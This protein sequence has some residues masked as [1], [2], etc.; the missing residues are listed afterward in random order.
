MTH[1][2]Y[3]GEALQS[4]QKIQW[5][6]KLWD[7]NDEE[8]QI[9]TASF[10]MGLLKESDWKATWITGDYKVDR[11][12][13]YP[14]DCFRKKFLAE[15]IRSARLYV[16]ACGLYEGRINGAKVGTY[17]LMPGHTNYKKRVQYQTYDVTALLEPGENELTFQLADGWYR[18]SCGANALKNQ[19][20]TETKLLAQLEI[21]DSQGRITR[22]CTDGTW[23]W[24]NDGPIR[25]ADNKDG[26]V[27][28]ANAVPSYSGKAKETVN[29]IVPVASNNVPVEEHETWSSALLTTPSGKHVLDFHQNIA[30]YLSFRVNAKRGQKIML[31]FGEMLDE[32]GEFTQKNIQIT[33][34]KCTT[35]LQQVVYT[36]KDG[37]NEYKT[38]FAIFGFQY[39]EVTMDGELFPEDFTAI[40]V[41]SSMERTGWVE[42]SNKLLNRFLE[43]TVWSTKNNHADLPT[44]CPT[45][46]RHGW[47]GDSGGGGAGQ[48]PGCL[49]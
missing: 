26:E 10:E 29:P 30:G 8:G 37:L 36:C 16:T 22:I 41:Y 33:K 34:K 7:E 17:V 25:F 2:P 40:A 48:R 14:V 42:T 31:R 11:K 1:I 21:T 47:A 3:G 32:N 24:S 20:G 27:Y 4:R 12:K 6:V 28:D 44:D 43:S 35:P 45:R 18:G 38:R 23:D 49:L 5:S 9:S 19:Y 46:E 13:R 39:V 15:N